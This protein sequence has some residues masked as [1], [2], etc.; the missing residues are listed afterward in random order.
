MNRKDI[1]TTFLQ[2]ASSGSVREAYEKYVH[3]GFIHHNG[4]FKG[5][6]ESLM[7]GMEEAHKIQPQ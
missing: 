6:K 2:L 3:A 5:D 1:A 4:Y 7:K